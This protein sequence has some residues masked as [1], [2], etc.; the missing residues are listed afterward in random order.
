MATGLYGIYDTV[1][2]FI[3]SDVLTIFKHEAPAVRMFTDLLSGNK[4]AIA[5]HPADHQ[6]VRLGWIN[7]DL[8]IQAEY[9]VILDGKAWLAMQDRQPLPDLA[10]ATQDAI[11]AFRKPNSQHDDNQS[12]QRR[13]LEARR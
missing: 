13:A 4:G 6:L 10:Q 1:A 5:Q 7:D 9:A 8:E 2:K 11:Q 12:A 3:L